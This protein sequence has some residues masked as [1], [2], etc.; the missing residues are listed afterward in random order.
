M[1]PRLLRGRHRWDP[2]GLPALRLSPPVPRKPVGACTAVG[3]PGWGCQGRDVPSPCSVPTG[4][5]G[6]VRVW[7]AAGT[8]AP[9]ASRATPGSTV[10]GEAAGT[11]KPAP[12]THPVPC[13]L[14]PYTHPAILALMGSLPY[15]HP[16]TPPHGLTPIYSPQN[17]TLIESLLYTYPQNPL[18]LP[19]PHIP[20]P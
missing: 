6:P 13:G 16:K 15:T 17:R 4:F 9:P 2:R 5:P 12:N 19:H 3:V 1:C 20:T 14:T 7:E 18:P 11:P 8:A 10:S